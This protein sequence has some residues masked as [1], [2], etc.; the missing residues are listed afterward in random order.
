MVPGV[1]PPSRIAPTSVSC[2]FFVRAGVIFFV[3][4]GA[5]PIWLGRGWSLGL[6]VRVWCGGSLLAER[7]TTVAYA[8]PPPTAAYARPGGLSRPPMNNSG[9]TRP[10]PSAI[11]QRS[12]KSRSDD[13]SSRK[14]RGEAINKEQLGR[15][16]EQTVGLL[17]PLP[18]Y[19]RS[20]D[21]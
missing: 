6:G 7:R 20:S 21:F 15:T 11:G 2:G 9:L 12:K 10:P 17:H 13:A 8:W 18:G 19:M 5:G 4:V 1:F 14:I 16:K 3:Q